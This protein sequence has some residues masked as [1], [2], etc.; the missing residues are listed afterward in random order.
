AAV[1]SKPSTY[2]A[3]TRIFLDTATLLKPLL[4]GLA[5]EPDVNTELEVMKQT[6][7]TR[8]NLEKVARITDL[9]IT[10]ATPVEMER[11]LDGL[12]NRTI[13]QTDGRFLLSISYRD[14]DPVRARDVVQAL[15]R[16][17]IDTNLGTTREEI[18][19]AEIFLDRQI[20]QYEKALETAEQQL[21]KFK[22]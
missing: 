2:T 19:D 8:S 11:L 6:L 21:V 20:A 16:V 10:A 14:T 5:I 18:A 4:E 15:T 9:D 1:I 3:S 13:V 22:E 17:F 12:R 7:T